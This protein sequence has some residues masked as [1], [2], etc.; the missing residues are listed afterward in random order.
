MIEMQDGSVKAQLG[1]PDMKVPI[2]YALTHP[3]HLSAPWEQL[4]FINSGDL[5]FE[6]PDHDRFPCISL[7]FKALKKM[8]TAPAALNLSNDYAVRRFLDKE[9]KFTDI[10]KIN[11]SVMD[12]HNWIE[13]PN[14]EDLQYLDSWVHKTVFNFH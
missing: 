1:V 7:A 11:K 10:P 3:R 4:D 2:Q 12:S 6:Q 8:G 14:L 13:H 9:I 5:T